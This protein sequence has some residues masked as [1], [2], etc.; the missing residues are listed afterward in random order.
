MNK[1]AHYP[2]P[3]RLW[4]WL[5]ALAITGLLLTVI[6]TA[7]ISKVTVNAKHA[8]S[9]LAENHIPISYQQSLAIGRAVNAPYWELHLWLG[10]GLAA[11]LVF[12]LIT[13]FFL[14]AD[15]RLLRKIIKAHRARKRH[16]FWVKTI[17]ML[18]YV[19]LLSTVVTGLLLALQDRYPVL[20]QYAL[21]HDLHE[22]GTYFFLLFITAHITGVSIAEHRK[23]KGS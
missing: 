7:T 17:Y 14:P 13:E 12:R 23:S 15:Q 11:L 1:P 20:Q 19:V 16:G 22:T 3:I 5:S 4:H 10:Y 6:L 18:F 21:I 8:R 9:I 2:W